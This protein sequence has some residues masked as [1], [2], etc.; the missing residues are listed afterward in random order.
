MTG[1]AGGQKFSTKDKDNDKNSGGSCAQLYKGGWWYNSCHQ[2][3]L[4]GLYHNGDHTSYADGVNWYTW[5]GYKYSMKSARMMIR[6]VA[7]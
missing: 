4:N 3:N 2:S 7:P 1:T 6:R 5:K